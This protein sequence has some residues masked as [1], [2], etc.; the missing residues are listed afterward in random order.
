MI[1]EVGPDV[2]ENGRHAERTRRRF[3]IDVLGPRSVGGLRSPAG[4]ADE[5]GAAPYRCD[6]GHGPLSGLYRR[7]PWRTATY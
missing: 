3:A 5:R 7:E 6:S 4:S 1:P 2:S